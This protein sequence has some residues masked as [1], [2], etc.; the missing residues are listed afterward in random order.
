VNRTDP[1]GL[2]ICGANSETVCQATEDALSIV[3]S[4]QSKFKEGSDDWNR[5]NNVLTTFGAAG[6]DNGII[7]QAGRLEEGNPGTFTRSERGGTVT[8]D[9][10]Q[11]SSS[12]SSAKVSTG[13]YVAGVY[14]HEGDH[15][16]NRNRDDNV[17][18][19]VYMLEESAYRTQTAVYLGIGANWN[20][21]RGW[22]SQYAGQTR[23]SFISA[24]AAASRERRCGNGSCYGPW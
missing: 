8:I 24:G 4:A 22:G 14:A 9:L 10:S 7:V 20:G 13:V 3:R 15:A 11:M 23:R 12:A 5:L 6:E 21:A 19:T 2:Y 17:A 16:F 18:A 1:T